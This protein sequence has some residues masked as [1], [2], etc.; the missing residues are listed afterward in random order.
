MFS[1]G[2]NACPVPDGRSCS[3]KRRRPHQSQLLSQPDCDLG[4]HHHIFL[5]Q[6][7]NRLIDMI[8]NRLIDHGFHGYWHVSSVSLI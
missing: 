8:I 6:D 5:R 3:K 1:S 2:E 7:L 4:N